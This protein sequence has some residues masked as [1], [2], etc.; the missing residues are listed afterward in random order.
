MDRQ[1]NRPK[2]ICPFLAVGGSG[3]GADV[4]EFFLL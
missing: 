2:P 4:S 3:W 1:T